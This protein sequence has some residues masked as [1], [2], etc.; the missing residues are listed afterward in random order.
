MGLERKGAG[1][2]RPPLIFYLYIYIYT[3]IPPFLLIASILKN[4]LIDKQLIEAYASATILTLY[5]VILFYRLYKFYLKQKIKP[6][7]HI[8]AET[9]TDAWAIASI[10]VLSLWGI[11]IPYLPYMFILVIFNYNFTLR[12]QEANTYMIIYS[13]LVLLNSSNT[14]PLI[15]NPDLPRINTLTYSAFILLHLLLV[16]ILKIIGN[17]TQ[18]LTLNYII[19]PTNDYSLKLLKTALT[20]RLYLHRIRNLIN[21]LET[22]PHILKD[23]TGIKE[24]II[25]LYNTLEN[26]HIN[27]TRFIRKIKTINNLLGALYNKKHTTIHIQDNSSDPLQIESSILSLIIETLE[28]AYKHANPL[29]LELIFTTTGLEVKLTSRFPISGQPYKKAAGNTLATNYL[30]LLL[31]N[32]KINT[33]KINTGLFRFSIF[34]P[35]RK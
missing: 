22:S 13:L 5:G 21:Q 27:K 12:T 9:S 1:A 19:K 20:T 30:F 24:Y 4:I 18:F 28:N 15:I 14:F 23:S 10:L 11:A 26:T 16:I 6:L 29:K 17:F 32:A 2:K 8:L 25:D 34:I 33:Q 31:H 7:T 3:V 35:F